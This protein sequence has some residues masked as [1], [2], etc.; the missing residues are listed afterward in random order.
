MVSLL[1]YPHTVISQVTSQKL[2]SHLWYISEE[3]AVLGLFDWRVPPERK[4]LMVSAMEQPAPENP[5]KAS[6][7]RIISF[8]WK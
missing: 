7:G 3:L 1:Q 2:S 5:P 4:A 8:P 6:Q